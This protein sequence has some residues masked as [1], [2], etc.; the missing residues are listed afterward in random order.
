M[1]LQ[2]CT[3]AGTRCWIYAL[4]YFNISL[5]DCGTVK[6]FSKKRIECCEGLNKVGIKKEKI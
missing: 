3:E 6:P 5:L 1:S 2:L 4:N